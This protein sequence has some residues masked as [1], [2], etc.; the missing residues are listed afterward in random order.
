VNIYQVTAEG[1]IAS[2]RSFWEFDQL[3]FS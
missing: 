3:S 1:R 2:L